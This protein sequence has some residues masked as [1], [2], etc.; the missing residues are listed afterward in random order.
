MMKNVLVSGATGF[1]GSNLVRRLLKESYKVIILKRSFSNT[2]RIDD[3]IDNL[4]VYNT[5][6]SNLEQP[7]YDHGKIDSVIHTATC[8]GRNNENYTDM[9]KTNVLFPLKLLEISS[10][11]KTDTFFNTDTV[12]PEYFNTYS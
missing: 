5:N 12:L 11:F 2:K 9:V 1:L 3:I 4:I 10:F 7:F 8:Y 6:E